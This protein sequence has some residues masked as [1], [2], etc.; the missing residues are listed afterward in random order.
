MLALLQLVECPSV[1]ELMADYEFPWEDRP[2]LRVVRA[3]EAEVG[4]DAGAVEGAREEAFGDK[5]SVLS[6]MEKVLSTN[7]VSWELAHLPKYLQ[8]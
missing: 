4:E 6:V 7:T 1:Y 8:R 5:N 3:R 2:E